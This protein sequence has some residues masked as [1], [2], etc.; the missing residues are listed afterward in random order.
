MK[1]GLIPF[2]AE[3]IMGIERQAKTVMV[4]EDNQNR[5]FNLRRFKNGDDSETA[6]VEVTDTMSQWEIPFMDLV[7]ARSKGQ[8]GFH[9]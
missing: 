9:R 8:L 1:L 6:M 3:I 7:I 5:T 4:S 2:A